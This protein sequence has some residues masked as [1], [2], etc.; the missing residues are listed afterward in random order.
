MVTHSKKTKQVKSTK[1]ITVQEIKFWLSGILEFQD[2][3]WLPNRE[4]WEN[5][6]E[7]IMSLDETIKEVKVPMQNVLPQQSM[8]GQTN[9]VYY[10]NNNGQNVLPPLNSTRTRLDPNLPIEQQVGGQ[11]LMQQPAHSADGGFLGPL[12]P[13]PAITIPTEEKVEEPYRGGSPF[14]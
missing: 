10:E 3:G 6:K 5:I 9:A 4:Q 1:P 11:R 13:A 2:E 14:A 12:A 8:Q 7:K